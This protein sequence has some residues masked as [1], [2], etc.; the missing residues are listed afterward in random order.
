MTRI[1]ANAI[2]QSV[3][4]SALAKKRVKSDVMG[5]KKTS[6]RV[7]PAEMLRDDSAY[8]LVR[9]V[10]EYKEHAEHWE[11]VGNGQRPVCPGEREH[12]DLVYLP[13]RC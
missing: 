3:N 6:F 9:G 13:L 12:R 8:E 4:I 10:L 1:S 2:R 7:A 5:E 11:R